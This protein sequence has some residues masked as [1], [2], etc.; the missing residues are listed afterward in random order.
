MISWLNFRSPIPRRIYTKF[1]LGWPNGF[2]EDVWKCWWGQNLS[3]LDQGQRMTL[4]SDTC[5]SSCI[6]IYTNF[7]I[8]DCNSFWEIYYLGVFLYKSIW[9][10]IWSL[11]KKSK[12]YLGSSFEKTSLGSTQVPNAVYQV[13]ILLAI[14]FWRRLNFN[15]F[16]HIWAWW[17]SWSCDQDHLNKLSF[18][19]PIKGPHEICLQLAYWFLRGRCLKSVDD[20]RRFRPTYTIS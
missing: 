20:R 4:T 10:K 2:W 14:R 15:V 12:M 7:Y 16:Y 5:I 9:N 8:I 13:S 19:H 11:W 1:D 6:T 3:A 18:P 17:P